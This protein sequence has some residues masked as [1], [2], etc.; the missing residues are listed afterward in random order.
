[1]AD[2]S[3]I[4]S[5]FANALGTAV[6]GWPVTLTNI[7]IGFGLT[8][9]KKGDELGE[10]QL[11]ELKQINQN[12]TGIR[13]DLDLIDSDLNGIEEV[14]KQ[15]LGQE[16]LSNL[17]SKQSTISDALAHIETD[18][19]TYQSYMTPQ[20]SGQLPK[21]SPEDLEIL[22]KRAYD[23]TSLT[24]E[25]AITKIQ[26]AVIGSGAGDGL[27]DLYTI[28]LLNY[29]SQKKAN[30]IS[31][32][33]LDYVANGLVSYFARLLAYQVNGM[34]VVIE[35]KCMNR[36]EPSIMEDNWS[37][38]LNSVNDQSTILLNAIWNLIKGWRGVVQANMND[39]IFIPYGGSAYGDQYGIASWMFMFMDFKTATNNFSNNDLLAFV[40]GGP[41][42]PGA[43]DWIQQ[44]Y[45]S[46]LESLEQDY[47]TRAENLIAACNLDYINTRRVVIHVLF[48][49]GGD[50][51]ISDVFS[52]PIKLEN[53]SDAGKVDV[54]KAD[55]LV[56]KP[57]TSYPY[58]WVRHVFDLNADGTYQMCDMRNSFP[59]W[60]G[61]GG[62]AIGWS[63]PFQSDADLKLSAT[64]NSDNPVGI[65]R[66]APYVQLA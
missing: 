48:Y 37:E 12:L 59:K 24:D 23:S 19:Q 66:F 57:P 45:N 4:V 25:E 31:S 55:V 17:L 3:P 44:Y 7:L 60:G 42:S 13:T 43:A 29:L 62:S 41:V 5:F 32:E 58:F 10:Q 14:L 11:K 30:E 51:T 49:I 2:I 35:C 28:L 8:F 20:A 54:R 53:V 46:T 63:H 26:Q 6:G 34:A 21:V 33:D 56:G 16:T 38:F 40:P 18:F 1:M 39:S 47:F 27:I 9:I 22:A 15:I 50:D 36:V 64:V 52:Q 65:I 61:Q